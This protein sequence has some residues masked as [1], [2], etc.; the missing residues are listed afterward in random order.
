M[1]NVNRESKGIPQ[2]KWGS[3][4]FFL[5]DRLHKIEWINRSADLVEC[6]SFE[7]GRSV[8]YPWTYTKRKRK[9]AFLT[10]QVSEMVNRHKISVLR[11]VLDGKISPPFKVGIGFSSKYLWGERNILE[12]HDYLLTVHYGRKRKDGRVTPYRLPSKA[13]L[14]AKMN[15]QEVLYVKGSNGEFVPVWNENT[16]W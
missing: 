12:L 14:L 7:D 4:Y 6:W 8:Q 1:T 13:E 9:K 15:H 11:Y 16:E 3:S 10:G 2:Y 5:D